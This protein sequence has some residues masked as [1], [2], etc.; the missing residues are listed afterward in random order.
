MSI[1][2]GMQPEDLFEQWHQDCRARAHAQ[3]KPEG[4]DAK[5]DDFEAY[6]YIWQSWIKYLQTLKRADGRYVRWDEA[7]GAA[8]VNFLNKGGI[9]SRKHEAK[10]S[11]IT[12]RRYW[13]VLDRIYTFAM[14]KCF[15]QVNP[16]SQV[17]RSEIPKQENHKGHVLTPKVWDAAMG[18]L[19]QEPGA[20]RGEVAT[21]NRALLLVLFTMGLMPIEV[22]SLNVANYA[23]T[24]EGAWLKIEGHTDNAKRQLEIPQFVRAALDA[25]LQ[26]RAASPKYCASQALFSAQS[27]KAMTDETLLQ[28]VRGHLLDACTAAGEPPPQRLG[29]QIIR[30]TR[31]V[32]WLMDGVPRP[33]V[34]LRAGLKDEHGLT[35]L[36][37]H[38]TKNDGPR[39][40]L[41]DDSPLGQ[42]DLFKQAA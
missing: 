38:V 33:V 22:R 30:N 40:R 8:V 11:D 41:N 2:N 37:D 26:V 4:P 36:I 42:L 23:S 13:R 20:G 5:G 7:D 1:E 12:K 14:E 25:W 32:K 18:A 6:R 34:V 31:I 28:I 10:V 24:G 21:R 29:P 27:G 9:E 35:H 17:M 19:K 16:A 15:A 3:A 39:V